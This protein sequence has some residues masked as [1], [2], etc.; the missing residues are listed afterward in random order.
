MPVPFLASR[1]G[2]RVL[3]FKRV[4]QMNRFVIVGTLLLGVFLVSVSRI[5][6]GGTSVMNTR[7]GTVSASEITVGGLKWAVAK[8]VKVTINGKPGKISDLKPGYAVFFTVSGGT[9]V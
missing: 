5:E 9:V 6:A 1:L 8:N 2:G 3:C 4:S 7:I